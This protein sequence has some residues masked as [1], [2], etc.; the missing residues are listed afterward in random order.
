MDLATI[1]PLYVCL[2]FDSKFSEV[3]TQALY[4]FFS[5]QNIF[6]LF[7]KKWHTK[8]QQNHV[9]SVSNLVKISIKFALKKNRKFK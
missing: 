9:Y 5:H 6:I 7:D 3:K 8:V 1:S 2:D 4:N